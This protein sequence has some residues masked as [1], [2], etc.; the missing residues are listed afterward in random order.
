MPRTSPLPVQP[1]PGAR[2]A[3]LPQCALGQAEAPPTHPKAC[4]CWSQLGSVQ[5]L[6][7]VTSPPDKTSRVP[8][9]QTRPESVLDGQSSF[10]AETPPNV[11]L[12]LVCSTLL[13][14][15]GIPPCLWSDDIDIRGEESD[16][17]DTSLEGS[18]RISPG[19]LE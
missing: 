12:F 16:R 10:L 19:C 2:V 8:G 5:L 3:A 14:P 15:R 11:W 7:S 4:G 13:A 6:G 18:G 17:L 9:F 1:Y